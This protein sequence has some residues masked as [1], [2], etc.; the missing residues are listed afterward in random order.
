MSGDVSS[1]S[2]SVFY[3]PSLD[4]SQ[5]ADGTYYYD[6]RWYSY[7]NILLSSAAFDGTALEHACSFLV[8]PEDGV[9]DDGIPVRYDVKTNFG[10]SDHLAVKTIL[11]YY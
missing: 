10:Y 1:L 2:P 11:E 9:D 5:D 6:G 4:V 8:Y 3:A 7:D